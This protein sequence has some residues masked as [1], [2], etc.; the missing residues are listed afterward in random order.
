MY[1][2]INNILAPELGAEVLDLGSVCEELLGEGKID[3]GFKDVEVVWKNNPTL[4]AEYC[5]RDSQLVLKLGN[6][7]L[8]QIFEIARLVGQLPFDI[9]RMTYGQLVEWYLIRRARK[10]GELA[11]NRPI[12]Q[13]IQE[14]RKLSPYAGAFVKEPVV[15][16]HKN[17]IVFD[18]RSLY[19]SIIVTFNISPD[20]LNC[21]CCKGDGYKAPELNYWF[22]KK[23]KGFIPTVIK[24]LVE[25]RRKIKKKIA[26]LKKACRE[27]LTAMNNRQYALKIIANAMYGYQGFF[28]ARWYCREAAEA[29]AA[30]GRRYI[31]KVIKWAEKAGFAVIYADTDSCFVKGEKKKAPGFLRYVNKKLPGIMELELQDVYPKGLF[32]PRRIGAAVAKKRYALADE[33]GNITIRGLEVVRRD[34]CAA[35]KDL[36]HRLLEIVLLEEDVKKAVKLTHEIIK[37]IRTRKIDLADLT[38]REQLIRPIETYDVKSPH[39]VAA[40]KLIQRGHPI[41]PGSLISFIITKGQ[42]SI[43]DRAEPALDVSAEEVD[44]DYYVNNQI[45]PAAMRVLRVLGVEEEEFTRKEVGLKK[46]L[47]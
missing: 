19:P 43:S 23:R 45:I 14:R 1:K 28:G 17:I 27:T 21:E 4:L 8:P 39:V 16:M 40:Q 44:V 31:K 6:L 30:F 10:F 9:S 3:L 29:C 12:T 25:K 5:L 2:F 26:E 7:L 34:W 33:R 36:Q 11:P 18:F 32:I 35:A 22:C 38:I 41:G 47:K 24:D 37:K 20:T 42:G 15:G 13:V 46:F